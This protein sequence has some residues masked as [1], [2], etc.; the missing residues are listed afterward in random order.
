MLTFSSQLPL[1]Y[2]A[3]Y[4]LQDCSHVQFCNLIY[5]TVNKKYFGLKI[6][7]TIRCTPL[8]NKRPVYVP[9]TKRGCSV[10]P[11]LKNTLVQKEDTS[12]VLACTKRQL[13]GTYNIYAT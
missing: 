7:Q 3:S 6:G 5:F 2:N 9:N 8:M 10:V 12:I 11:I 4:F 1:R 13:S